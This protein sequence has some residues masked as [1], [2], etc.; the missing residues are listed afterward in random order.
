M[1]ND[2]EVSN[3]SIE[4]PGLG[5]AADATAAQGY[6]GTHAMVDIGYESAD[7][8]LQAPLWCE[9]MRQCGMAGVR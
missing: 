1:A 3:G 4:A 8:A 5:C 9:A 6:A 2:D 7:P